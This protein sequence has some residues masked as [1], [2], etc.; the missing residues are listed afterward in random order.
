MKSVESSRDVSARTEIDNI[1]RRKQ[2]QRVTRIQK[3]EKVGKDQKKEKNQGKSIITKSKETERI[4]TKNNQQQESRKS[5]SAQEAFR[6]E[7]AQMGATSKIYA[8]LQKRG[9]KQPIITKEQEEKETQM[10][11]EK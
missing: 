4:D 5:M 7:I 11:N 10:E 6:K 2:V 9:N 8:N 3:V 1:E